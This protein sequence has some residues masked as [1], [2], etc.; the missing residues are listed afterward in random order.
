MPAL[1]KIHALI[2]PQNII[3]PQLVCS[4]KI[5]F[6]FNNEHCEESSLQMTFLIPEN[7]EPLNLHFQ[8]SIFRPRPNAVHCFW[9]VAHHHQSAISN[10]HALLFV[11]TPTARLLLPTSLATSSKPGSEHRGHRCCH[12]QQCLRDRHGHPR[13]HHTPHHHHALAW[14]PAKPRSDLDAPHSDALLW[15]AIFCVVFIFFDSF[16]FYRYISLD[17]PHSDALLEDTTYVIIKKDDW[18]ANNAIPLFYWSGMVPNGSD[19]TICFR[20]A[21]FVNRAY[22]QYTRGYSFPIWTNP[23]KI[24]FPGYGSFSGAHPSI[25]SYWDQFFDFSFPSYGRF[26]KK[27]SGRRAKKVFPTALWGHRL[28]VTALALNWITL[29]I[30]TIFIIVTVTSCI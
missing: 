29:I 11:S 25:W 3:L 14:Q 1:L 15:V 21:I 6:I 16:C 10:Q 23:K 5:H 20:I 17:P 2:S 30:S 28:P 19:R 9:T 24:P 7:T 26:R 8:F 18:P 13:H 22:H 12:H 27:K 4:N